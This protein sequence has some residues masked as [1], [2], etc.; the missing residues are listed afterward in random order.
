[1]AFPHNGGKFWNACKS[2][3]WGQIIRRVI[4]QLAAV[5]LVG[6]ALL[7][8][9]NI[10]TVYGFLYKTWQFLSEKNN[11]DVLSKVITTLGLIIAGMFA[12]TRFIMGRVLRPMANIVCKDGI[13]PLPAVNLHWFEVQIENKGTVAIRNYRILAQA[14]YY[15]NSEMSID[16]RKEVSVKFLETLVNDPKQHFVHFPRNFVNVGESAYEHAVLCIPKTVLGVSFQVSVTAI[17]RVLRT[18]YIWTR[19]LTT[20]N[21]IDNQTAKNTGVE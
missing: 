16:S 21:V 4:L 10:T 5:M 8:L 17:T 3:P 9:V 6:I 14:T 19:V 2:L 7:L 20:S 18:P 13:I 1:M 11:S 12:Y 15:E